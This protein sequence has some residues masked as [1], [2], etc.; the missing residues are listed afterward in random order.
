MGASHATT[1]TQACMQ[2]GKALGENPF[3]I[4][5]GAIFVWDG[6]QLVLMETVN[7]N[8]GNKEIATIK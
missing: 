6:S 2:L 5:F 3:E 8:R 4:S 1:V 7:L